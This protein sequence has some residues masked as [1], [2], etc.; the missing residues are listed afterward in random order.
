[1]NTL[2]TTAQQCLEAVLLWAGFALRPLDGIKD[3]LANPAPAELRAKASKIWVVAVVLAVVFTA[4]MFRLFGIELQNADFLICYISIILLINV[5]FVYLIHVGLGLAGLKSDINET[6]AIYTVAFCYLPITTALNLPGT[7]KIYFSLSKIK[8]LDLNLTES[9]QKIS[10]IINKIDN[11]QIILS[12][13][14]I[15]TG[16]L[17]WNFQILMGVVFIEV[18]CWWYGY[19]RQRAYI[20]VSIAIVIALVGIVLVG[21]PLIM[22]TIYSYIK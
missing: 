21:V 5:A 8:K 22:L 6:S 18:L 19:P 17:T 3:L 15:V 13:V 20:A 16:T 7:Y 14:G 2:V 12:I 10:E 9:I 1:M 4:P 11:D